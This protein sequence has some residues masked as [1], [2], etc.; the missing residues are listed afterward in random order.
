[1]SRIIGF[2]LVVAASVLPLAAQTS[3]LQGIVKDSQNAVV[4]FVVVSL[5]ST[6]TGTARQVL[7]GPD[8]TYSFLQMPP[9]PYK[10]EAKLPGFSVFAKDVRLQIDTPATLNVAL[11]IGELTT[12]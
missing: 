9:G 1:M 11:V 8:G 7:S 10:I 2:I 5:T 3:S 6:E 4:P 12:S